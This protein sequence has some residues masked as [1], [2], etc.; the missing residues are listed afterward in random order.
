MAYWEAGT[1]MERSR[2]GAIKS[3]KWAASQW[4]QVTAWYSTSTVGEK[5]MHNG[6]FCV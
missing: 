5:V 6:L 4:R 1:Y 3:A 2:G